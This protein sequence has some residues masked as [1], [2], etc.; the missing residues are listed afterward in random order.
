MR[1]SPPSRLRRRSNFCQHA[2]EIFCGK[3]EVHAEELVTRVFFAR[4]GEGRPTNV[5]H[6]K[7]RKHAGNSSVCPCRRRWRKEWRRQVCWE[8]RSWYLDRFTDGVAL[9]H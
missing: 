8:F 6:F 9:C 3:V 5:Y 4:F 2:H 7:V 1:R